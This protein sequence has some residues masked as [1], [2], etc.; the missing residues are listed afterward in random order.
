MFHEGF[1]MDK[2][3]YVLLAAILALLTLVGLSEAGAATIA[4]GSNF[5]VAL[6]SDGTL[7]AWGDNTYGELGNGTT[8][9]AA[10]PT[11]IGGGTTWSAVAAGSN[12]T[13]AL[14]SDGTLWAWGDNT[15]GELGNGTTTNAATP[16]HIGG[17]TTWSAVAVGSNFTVAVASNGTL[18]AWGTTPTVN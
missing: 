14:Q 13:V 10:T 11:R 18:W 6:Q 17:G 7:W 4:A 8:T 5:T 2:K 15:Y 3:S 1:I 16:T 12:F 9:N